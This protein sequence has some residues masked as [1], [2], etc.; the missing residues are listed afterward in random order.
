MTTQKVYFRKNVIKLNENKEPHDGGNKGGT[1]G[2]G[3]VFAT[4]EMEENE[5]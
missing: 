2:N 4:R 3:D 1:N 5:C